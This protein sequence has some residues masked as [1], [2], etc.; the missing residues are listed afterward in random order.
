MYYED[1]STTDKYP[2]TLLIRNHSGGM[3]WQLYHVNNKVE[4][5]ILSWNATNNVFMAIELVDHDDS[6]EETFEGWRDNAELMLS[7]SSLEEYKE[8]VY[9]KR[10]LN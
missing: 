3:I 2:K 6:F 4:A 1:N 10:A 9:A 7:C 5:D 8:K